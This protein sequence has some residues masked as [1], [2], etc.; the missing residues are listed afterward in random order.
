MCTHTVCDEQDRHDH[1]IIAGPVPD[2]LRL[3]LHPKPSCKAHKPS[4][5]RQT[6]PRNL[7]PKNFLVPSTVNP[8][9]F[10]GLKGLSPY[11][12]CGC[13]D[14]LLK[15]GQETAGALYPPGGRPGSKAVYTT[16]KP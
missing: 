6:I 16:P 10:V 13:R 9:K 2:T 5:H 15:S 11:K 7:R 14:I 12:L 8:L 4:I 1:D 3:A